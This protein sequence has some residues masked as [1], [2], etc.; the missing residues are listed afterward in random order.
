MGELVADIGQVQGSLTTISAVGQ[1]VDSNRVPP[2]VSMCGSDAVIDS[3]VQAFWM[4]EQQDANVWSCWAD[5]AQ[6]T[7]AGLAELAQ[8]D[9]ELAA[10]FE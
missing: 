6:R 5:L 7:S 3:L 1:Q 8:V 10:V 9:A 2:S 4:I